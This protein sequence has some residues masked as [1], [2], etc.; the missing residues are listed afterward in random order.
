MIDYKVSRD[1]ANGC[2]RI[3]GNILPGSK[4][5]ERPAD[6]KKRKNLQRQ[7]IS[8]FLNKA[9]IEAGIDYLNCISLN[10]HF[11]TN[12]G[13]FIGALSRY[14]KCFQ[15]SDARIALDE[16]AFKRFSPQSVADFER[17]KNWRNKHY[18]HDENGMIQTCA[19]LLIAPRNHSSKFGGPPSVVWNTV[20]INYI[21]EGQ[22]LQS[23]LQET[24]KFIAKK[25]DETGDMIMKELESFSHNDLLALDDAHI[26]LATVNHPEQKRG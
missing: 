25:I 13:L 7:F 5:V 11:R 22:L 3:E 8:F 18:I 26:E 14:F 10:N 1:E 15:S 24:W 20:P 23:L 6:T 9:D 21:Q 17:F 2:F 12:E 19:F 4:A 16:D